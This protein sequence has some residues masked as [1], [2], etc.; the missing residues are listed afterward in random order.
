[1]RV[2]FSYIYTFDSIHYQIYGVRMQVA[3][4]IGLPK[5]NNQ[6]LSFLKNKC[7]DNPRGTHHVCEMYV[8]QPRN[9]VK[10]SNRH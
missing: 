9:S 6:I 7:S 8:K 1:M 2:T 10:S 3:K 5:Y 4:E